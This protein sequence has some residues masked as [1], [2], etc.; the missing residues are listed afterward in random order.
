MGIH[1]SNDVGCDFVRVVVVVGVV[2]VVVVVVIV[3]LVLLGDLVSV[4]LLSRVAN[5]PAAFEP[6]GFPQ[7]LDVAWVCFPAQPV[8]PLCA[9]FCSS[10]VSRARGRHQDPVGHIIQVRTPR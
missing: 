7:E 8:L 5:Q 10:S 9:G 4:R 6:E 2:V 1:A 3:S